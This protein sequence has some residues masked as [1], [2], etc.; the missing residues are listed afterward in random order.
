MWSA[1]TCACLVCSDF[2]TLHFESLLFCVHFPHVIL[3]AF[4]PLCISIYTSVLPFYFKK[5]LTF[6]GHFGHIFTVHLMQSNFLTIMILLQFI[7][8][9]GNISLNNLT[10]IF[11]NIYVL[12]YM[13]YDPCFMLLVTLYFLLISR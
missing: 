5:C 4:F 11:L 3:N 8:V 10:V 2:V 7:Q 13:Y 1:G 9:A 6:I 12:S